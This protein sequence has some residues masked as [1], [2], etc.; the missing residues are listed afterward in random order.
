[1]T[2]PTPVEY[3]NAQAVLADSNATQVQKDSAQAVINA[4]PKPGSA[5]NA[6]A[7]GIATPK[8]RL[9][10]KV[11]EITTTTRGVSLL[12][13]E[14]AHEAVVN[15]GTIG[16]P[17]IRGSSYVGAPGSVVQFAAPSNPTGTISIG[18]SPEYAAQLSIGAVFYL[19]SA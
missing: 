17:A 7:P 5:P 19:V 1:M 4:Y 18:V 15:T 12:T 2:A 9:K 6:P 16:A 8:L 14:A 13:L 3:S 11:S 10:F